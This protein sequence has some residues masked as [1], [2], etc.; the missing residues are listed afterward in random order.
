MAKYKLSVPIDASA[1]DKVDKGHPLQVVAI[2]AKGKRTAQPVRLD[3]KK[4]T[5]TFNFDALPEGLRVF[6]G[7]GDAGPEDIDKLQ[8]VAVVNVSPRVFGA[9]SEATLDVIT[10]RPQLWDF[11]LRWCSTYVVHGRVVCA[12]G[13]PVPGATVCAYDVDWFLWWRSTQKVACATTNVHGEFT[14][15]FRWCCGWWP[16][17]WWRLRDW[18]LDVD[19][20]GRI[21]KVLPPELK[22]RPIPLPDPAPDFR[23]IEPLLGTQQVSR[24]TTADPRLALRGASAKNVGFGSETFDF[25]ALEKTRTVLADRLP[26][27][28]ELESLRLWPWWPWAPWFDCAPDLIFRATQD[29][30][31][32][33]TVIIDE[34][35]GATRWNIPQNLNVTLQAH[36]I[37]CCLPDL[38]TPT[39]DCLD[40]TEVCGID[41]HS[42]GG[43]LGNP[44]PT[45]MA[46]IPGD[47]P[48][49][50][51][52]GTIGIGGTAQAIHSA[53]YYEVLLDGVPLP[54]EKLAA[55]GRTYWDFTTIPYTL[56]GATFG[57][58]EVDGKIVY[59]TMSHYE[60]TH[61]G[62]TWNS[63]SG[64][65]WKDNITQL[66]AWV[67]STA[68]LPDG[69]YSL[70]VRTYKLNAGGHLDPVDLPVCGSRDPNV[71][72]QPLTIFVDN[73]L[74]NDPLHDTYPPHPVV[75][76]H[77]K[78]TEPDT[79]FLRISIVRGATEIADIDAC[80]THELRAGDKVR[81]RYYAY[82][83]NE[84][85]AGYQINLHWG[86][87]EAVTLVPGIAPSTEPPGIIGAPIPEADSAGPNYL[88]APDGKW[89]G[90]VMKVDLD[91]SHFPL[92]C[93]YL[94]QLIAWKRTIVS[95]DTQYLHQNTSER[96]FMITKP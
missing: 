27:V 83:P 45:G 35:P 57:P 36:D 17:W 94:I 37:A 42:I 15:K 23:F 64:R 78:V 1:I 75:G 70:D 18:T 77:L 48:D 22:V 59:E 85:L 2:D 52:A 58:T 50:P 13:S 65:V 80:S 10:I 74:E 51:F 46:S 19:L 26:R 82:D 7:P 56:P 44:R 73:R 3:G 67:T 68:T 6:V 66:A 91:A 76:V 25:A 72:T 33:G 60:A 28:A 96:S 4:A 20:L 31:E 55:F 87:N 40:L 16:W 9:K 86:E 41:A 89:R 24:V 63:F 8:N 90:G 88:G 14:M 61:P 29:C 47:T 81:V 69:V 21:T 30:R 11:W 95:C 12:D 54:V 79:D 34:G 93:C 43:N 5:A 38:P 62:G 53:D 71:K 49:R 32:H 84:H 39:D 92:T